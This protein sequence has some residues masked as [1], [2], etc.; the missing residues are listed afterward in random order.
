MKNNLSNLYFELEKFFEGISL[1]CSKCNF[2]DCE[3]YIW[4]LPKEADLLFENNVPIIEINKGIP[5][6]HS[7]EEANGKILIDKP[8]PKCKL[9]CQDGKCAIHGIR[10]L[11]CRMY[12]VGLETVSGETTVVL[13]RDCLFSK[14]LSV[15]RKGVLFE[16]LR[17]LF[18]RVPTGLLSR[19]NRTY[20]E[21]DNISCHPDGSNSFE[22]IF[23][24]D[25][26]K[27]ERRA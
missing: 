14:Q 24:L 4:L 27:Q 25:R 22:E 16:K 23:L 10:P 5:F 1:V 11:V 21:V 12:P 26:T 9:R 15:E 13:H 20:R 19:I 2:P 17:A 8:K 6:I 7:F 18:G 3:G